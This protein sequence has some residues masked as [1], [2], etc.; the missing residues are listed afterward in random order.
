MVGN[1]GVELRVL[2]TRDMGKDEATAIRDDVKVLQAHWK[3]D[4]TGVKRSGART[5]CATT[6]RP[7]TS[8]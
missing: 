7:W 6:P 8:C 2:E 1:A 3:L 4:K 5:P